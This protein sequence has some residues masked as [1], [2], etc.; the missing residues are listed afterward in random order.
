M[1]DANNYE[2]YNKPTQ[3]SVNSF[4][5]KTCKTHKN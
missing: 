3:T 2:H 1:L 5:I 4:E